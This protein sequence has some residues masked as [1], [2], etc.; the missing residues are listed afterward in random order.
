M[1]G[2]PSLEGK[3]AAITLLHL[4]V[5]VPTIVVYVAAVV[6]YG[7]LRRRVKRGRRALPSVLWAPTPIINIRYSALADRAYGYRSETLVYGVYGINAG[8]DFDHVLD[9]FVRLPLIG[10]LAPYA[11]FLWAGFRFDAFGFFFDGGLLG[12]TP[13]WR[14]ELALL[15]LAGKVIV[16][17]PYGSD[18][19]LPSATRKL[20]RWN[21]YTD[22]PPGQEDRDE[23][24]VRQRLDAFAR[25]ATVM[26]GCADLVEDLPASTGCCC[27]PST[28]GAGSPSGKRTTSW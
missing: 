28:H 8:R 11:A 5:G 14:T 3:R 10:G 2:H 21:A 7:R 9:R 26:L 6:P 17:Y 19:R 1:N 23:S 16:V 4:V 12:H 18:A 20:G 24:A 27:T 22:V 15:R 13:W 25:H